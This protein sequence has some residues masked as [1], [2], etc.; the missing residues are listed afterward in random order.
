MRRDLKN[1]IGINVLLEAQD[2]A[3]TDTAS[4]LLDTAEF[5]GAVLAVT[6]GA[7]TGVDASNY[8]TPV[9]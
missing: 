5:P 2:L 4:A 9:L 7:L 8:L 3:S 6:I 1:N